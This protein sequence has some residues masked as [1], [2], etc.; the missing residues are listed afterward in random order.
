MIQNMKAQRLKLLV[1]QHKK[2]VR[3]WMEEIQVSPQRVGLVM[4]SWMEEIRLS[5]QPGKTACLS[6]VEETKL[7]IRP[8]PA[9]QKKKKIKKDQLQRAQT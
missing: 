1:Y 6:Q 3:P 4:Q 5:S 2:L 7:N 9:T 8:K